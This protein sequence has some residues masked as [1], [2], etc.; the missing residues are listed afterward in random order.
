VAFPTAYKCQ[1]LAGKADRQDLVI[2]NW[3]LNGKD[4]SKKKR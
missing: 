4:G 2:E 3:Q 1:V